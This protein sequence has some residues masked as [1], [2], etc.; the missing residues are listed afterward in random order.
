MGAATQSMQNLLMMKEGQHRMENP[1]AQP[2]A[3]QAAYH[4]MNNASVSQAAEM[5]MVS[6]LTKMYNEV[7]KK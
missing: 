5:D 7:E 6:R 2:G 4:N 3:A 1:Q